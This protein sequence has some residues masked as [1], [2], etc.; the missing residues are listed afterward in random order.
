MD[1]KSTAVKNPAAQA[2]GR[3]GGSKN[4][5]AQIRARAANAKRAGRPRRVCADCGEPVYG[6]HKDRR[7]DSHCHGRTWHWQKQ[8]EKPGR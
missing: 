4:T 3:L 8:S 1:D 5:A 6:G 7:Q 2:L